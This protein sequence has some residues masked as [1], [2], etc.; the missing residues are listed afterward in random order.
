MQGILGLPEVKCASIL[1]DEDFFELSIE[2]FLTNG[3]RLLLGKVNE[4]SSGDI[5]IYRVGDFEF[6]GFGYKLRPDF[7]G[8]MIKEKIK[9]VKD[10]IVHYDKIY[11]LIISW[12]NL[13]ELKESKD[14]TVS[15]IFNRRPDLFVP[16]YF[17]GKKYVFAITRWD[18]N[19]F[20]M[21]GDVS[22]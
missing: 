10:I 4:W 15:Q 14:E 20:R 6:F 1:Y 2:I 12:P 13:S 9:T 18:D 22:D 5:I 17:K 19:S 11:A 3:G 8:F 16:I 7:L 21:W